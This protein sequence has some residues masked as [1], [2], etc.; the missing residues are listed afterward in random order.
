MLDTSS[1]EELDPCSLHNCATRGITFQRLGLPPAWGKLFLLKA[2]CLREPGFNCLVQ[3]HW[4]LNHFP[5]CIKICP[6]IKRAVTC[7]L[8]VIF[9]NTE[10]AE[11]IKYPE[12]YHLKDNPWF[13][14]PFQSFTDIPHTFCQV[15]TL[16]RSLLVAA[17]FTIWISC[18]SLNPFPVARHLCYLTNKDTMPVLVDNIFSMF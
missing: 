15:I 9:E 18:D 17:Q 2:V 3:P 16:W 4:L 8:S 7:S 14:V 6:I 1:L 13:R 5:F 10:V 11:R 12:M